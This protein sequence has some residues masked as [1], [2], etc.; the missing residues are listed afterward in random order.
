MWE[1][2]APFEFLLNQEET[3]EFPLGMDPTNPSV[4]PSLFNNGTLKTGLRAT[5]GSLTQGVSALYL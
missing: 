1:D 4:G 3:L 2:G 5:H